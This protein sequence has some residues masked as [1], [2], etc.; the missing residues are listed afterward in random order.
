MDAD[1]DLTSRI[2]SAL[3]DLPAEDQTEVILAVIGAALKNMSLYRILEVRAEITCELAATIPLVSATLDLID[4]Q[5][6]LREIA[7]AE[8]WR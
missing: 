8:V 1:D 3:S 2:L 6:A 7:G 4:G 5:V